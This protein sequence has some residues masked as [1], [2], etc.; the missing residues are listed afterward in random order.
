MNPIENISLSKKNSYQYI[1]TDLKNHLE[2]R[3]LTN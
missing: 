3:S 2:N 1:K